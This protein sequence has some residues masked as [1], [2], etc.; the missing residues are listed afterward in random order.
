[1]GYVFNIFAEMSLRNVTN[2]KVNITRDKIFLEILNGCYRELA[3]ENFRLTYLP[4]EIDSAKHANRIL[5]DIKE[6]LSEHTL[7]N[8]ADS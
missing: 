5:S 8:V 4:P 2:D 6:I 1:M 7:V 3:L